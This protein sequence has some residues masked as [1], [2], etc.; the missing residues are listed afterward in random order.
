[1]V[2][3]RTDAPERLTGEDPA[4]LAFLPTTESI[5]SMLQSAVW[6]DGRVAARVLTCPTHRG[7]FHEAILHP[8]GGYT[9]ALGSLDG[10]GIPM[11]LS[12]FG[13]IS[14]IR[15]AV[16][17]G[18]MPRTIIE[19]INRGLWDFN[20]RV[21]E[22]PLSGAFFVATLP[23]EAGVLRYCN[24][25]HCEPFCLT[26]RRTLVRL[27]NVGPRLGGRFEPELTEQTVDLS[28][29]T[30]MVC[31][32]EGVLE[33]ISPGGERF[34]KRGVEAV[35]EGFPDWP[36][37]RQADLIYQAL[38]D[39]TGGGRT[40]KRDAGLMVADLRDP[41]SLR[42]ADWFNRRIQSYEAESWGELDTSVFL[43]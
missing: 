33:A 42:T 17:R 4:R 40:L 34:G 27:S 19:R 16:A 12:K 10:I 7:V 37:E 5:Y 23:N 43:G 1:M 9:V 29:L 28:N 3:S 30:R 11:E 20:R 18:E 14:A 38:R 21:R 13:V 26:A 25:G 24:A 35:L 39:H 8:D 22:N 2:M 15:E 32:S 31:V 6:P 36:V 41:L